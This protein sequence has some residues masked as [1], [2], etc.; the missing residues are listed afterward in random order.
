MAKGPE[1]AIVVLDPQT[2]RVIA[3]VGG[4]DMRVA[5]FNRAIQARRQA[6]STFKPIVFAAAI[7]SGEFTAAS[8][9]N[10]APEVYDLWKPENYKKGKFEG[11]VRLRYALAKSINTVA[12]RVAHDIGPGRVAEVA[13]AMGIQSKLPDGLSLALGSGEV[14]PLELTNAFATLAAE[15]KAIR[16]HI[17]TRVGS[18]KRAGASPGGRV[19]GHEHDEVGCYRGHRRQGGGARSRDRRQDRHLER[20]QG[21]LVHRRHP[22]GSDRRMGRLRR[23]LAHDRFGRVGW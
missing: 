18:K 9:V 4:Y 19:R 10:D 17:V 2:R 22:A 20:R 14:T 3:V 11:P 1:G 7:D 8:I 21:R 6:G 16:P 5:A 23:L 12:I 15:G 13:H